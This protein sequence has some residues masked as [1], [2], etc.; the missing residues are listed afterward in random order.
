MYSN[1]PSPLVYFFLE[2]I[3]GHEDLIGQIAFIYFH[4]SSN[5]LVLCDL[6]VHPFFNFTLSCSLFALYIGFRTQDKS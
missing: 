2:E 5:E 6:Q 4:L 3:Q 1:N